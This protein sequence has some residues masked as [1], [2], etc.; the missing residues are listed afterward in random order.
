M[1]HKDGSYDD[2]IIMVKEF[3]GGQDAYT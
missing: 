2:D 1:K 3:I